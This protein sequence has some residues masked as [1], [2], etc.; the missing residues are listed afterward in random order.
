MSSNLFSELASDLE[1]QELEVLNT[2]SVFEVH[3]QLLSIYLC[4]FDLCNAK[5]LWKRIPTDEK[6]SNPLLE[7]IWS[8]G[9]KLWQKEHTE[10]YRLIKITQWPESIQPFM[11]CLEEKYRQKSIQLIGKA[12]QTINSM[13]FSNLVGYS[14]QPEEAEKLLIKLQE[15]QGWTY[16]STL[17]LIVPKQSSTQNGGSLMR[18]EE[19]L[20]SLTQF[21]SFLEN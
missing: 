11:D 12:Y 21:V 10:V 17:N 16:D 4:N 6:V 9:Q 3:S 13:T 19:Q 2:M 8:V 15:E 7:Q 5:L 18:N 14:D 20:Q 1:K